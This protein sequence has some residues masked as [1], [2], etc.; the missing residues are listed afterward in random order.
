MASARGAAAER[1]VVGREDMKRRIAAVILLGLVW[2]CG[3]GCGRRLP[4][5]IAELRGAQNVVIRRAFTMAS[6]PRLPDCKEADLTGL[7]YDQGLTLSADQVAELWSILSRPGAIAPFPPRNACAFALHYGLS[8]TGRDT[9]QAISFYNGCDAVSFQSDRRFFQVEPKAA[10]RLDA[11]VGTMVI[12]VP[13]NRRYGIPDPP[14]RP[15]QPAA[16]Q[17]G[18]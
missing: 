11:L 2:S 10:A 6:D 16:P 18:I 1:Q 9:P 17:G 4:R 14:N 3:S 5:E 15:L 12:P 8:W 13:C 7:F